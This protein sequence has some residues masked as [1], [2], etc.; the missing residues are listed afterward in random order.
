MDDTIDNRGR[1]IFNTVTTGLIL[2]LGL[3]FFEVFKDLAKVV[4]WRILSR[5]EFDARRADLILGGESLKNVFQ[6]IWVSVY[7]SPAKPWTVFMCVAWLLVNIIAQAS[8]AILP[9]FAALESGINSTGITT[10][11]GNVTVPKLDCYY[12][13]RTDNADGCDLS[14]QGSSAAHSYGE[15]TGILPGQTCNYT[16]DDDIQSGGQDCPYLKTND[17]RE[18]AVRFPDENP[19]DI[20]GN[21]PNFRTGRMLKISASGCSGSAPLGP[22]EVKGSSVSS[23]TA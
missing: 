23:F 22:P 14:S 15:V 5:E 16:T 12:R 3:N 19:K 13:N 21:Y 10:S 2:G 7:S 8:V 18:Y 11:P 6:L 17:N 1:L 4:R 9:L 20:V